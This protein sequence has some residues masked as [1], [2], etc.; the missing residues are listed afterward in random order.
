MNIGK[1]MDRLEK[2]IEALTLSAE[3]TAVSTEGVELAIHRNAN[4]LEGLL[5]AQLVTM[6]PEQVA[7]YNEV[8]VNQ[9]V[10]LALEDL[11]ADLE[12]LHRD[13][14]TDHNGPA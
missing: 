11:E 6:S 10:E 4:A 14:D 9:H 7:A 5:T 1:R 12:N 3:S 2:L 13:T 8:S